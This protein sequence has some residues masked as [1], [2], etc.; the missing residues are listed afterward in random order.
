MCDKN[1]NGVEYD[2]L[3]LDMNGIIHPCCHP[4]QGEA[5]KT[6]EDMM[7][8]IYE[9]IDRIMNIVRPRRLLYLAVDGVAPRA[10]MNQQRSRRF[11]S[12][13]EAL[14]AEEQR[15]EKLAMEGQHVEKSDFDR[16]CITPGTEFMSSLRAY[17]EF[18]ISDRMTKNPGWRDIQVILSDANVPGEGEH[19]IM[20]FIRTQRVQK[21]YNPNTTHVIYGLDADLIFLALTTHE[22]NFY[23]LREMV[24][25]GNK[26]YACKKCGIPGHKPFQCGNTRYVVEIEGKLPY[27]FLDVNIFREYLQYELYFEDFPFEFERALDD[28]IFLCFFVGND[29]LPH[30]P[31]LEIREGAIDMLA[32][33]YKSCLK[34]LGG[35]ITNAGKIHM[36]RLQLITDTLAER[37][38]ELFA[39]R[40]E[41]ADQRITEQVNLGKRKAEIDVVDDIMLYEKDGKKRYYEAKFKNS[42]WE[43]RQKV[44]HDYIEGMAWVLQYYY[45]GCPSW[46]WFYPYHYAP[47][48]SDFQNLSSLKINFTLGTPFRPM[49]QLMAV[50]PPSS[51]QLVPKIFHSL[52]TSKK[53]PII[54]FYNEN[55]EYD[56]NG[57]MFLWQAVAKLD[58]IEEKRLL[59]AV[60]PLYL[61][62]TE[63]E[64]YMNRLEKVYLYVAP[65]NRLL[66]TFSYCTAPYIKE[67]SL[68]HKSGQI[69]GVIRDSS[70]CRVF[71]EKLYSPIP[72]LPDLRRNRSMSREFE[73]PMVPPSELSFKLL[74][75]YRERE[76][77]LSDKEL[78]DA[79]VYHRK[80][81]PHILQGNFDNLRPPEHELPRNFP[82]NR[83]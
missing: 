39:R 83:N 63:E 72:E 50:L 9:Y 75:G 3:Y 22:P 77:V 51:K 23:I 1:P 73:T 43:F 70:S 67:L 54:D 35:Y 11:R 45:H 17:L 14:Q 34:R 28:W 79:K 25:F 60:V 53:S 7:V 82:R 8:K 27:L 2:C 40:K 26:K 15:I 64:Q 42:S 58:F 81:N 16:N 31:A 46:Q 38:E 18:Y 41:Q 4:E 44:A 61:Q 10:K 20:D 71:C 56:M 12:R 32:D 68:V 55:F 76:H 52:M 80:Y 5:P 47:F 24:Y 48:A 66:S 49:E 36:D 59:D 69:A 33:I 21:D 57:K 62:L 19:K 78:N 13:M 6:E 29:F 37:E 74:P 65:G 30:S